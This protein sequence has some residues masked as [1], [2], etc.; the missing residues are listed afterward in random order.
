MRPWEAD[1]LTGIS[2]AQVRAQPTKG[3][4]RQHN[5]QK[6]PQVSEP[7]PETL[8]S[9]ILVF[10]KSRSVQRPREEWGVWTSH[11]WFTA[12]DWWR[13]H[14]FTDSCRSAKNPYQQGQTQERAT[15]TK[16]PRKRGPK[17]V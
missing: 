16:H 2:R 8:L 10:L 1:G 6:K 4:S 15:R 7:I 11:D 3:I 12:L 13:A 14:V 17:K 5:F 9:A